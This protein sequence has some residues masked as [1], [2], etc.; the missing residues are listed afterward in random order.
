MVF[1]NQLPK[2]DLHGES[3]DIAVILVKEF[4][5]DYYHLHTK[6]I[7]IIHGIG[8][9][10]LRQAVHEELK[11]NRLVKEYRLDSFNIGQTIVTLNL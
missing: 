2:L 6:E 9:N 1:S 7:I 4:I 11:K 5:E 3:K 10:I 8:K